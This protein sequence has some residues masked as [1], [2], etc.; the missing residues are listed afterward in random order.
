MGQGVID[1]ATPKSLPARLGFCGIGGEGVL[2]PVFKRAEDGAGVILRA[3][4]PAGEASEGALRLCR[5]M[6]EVREAD[7]LEEAAGEVDRDRVGFR[8]FEIKTLRIQV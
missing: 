1:T 4:E 3:F 7:M 6:G 8:P 2:I 5:E